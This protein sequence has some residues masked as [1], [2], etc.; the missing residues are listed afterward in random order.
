MRAADAIKPCCPA[1]LPA[2]VS[3][4]TALPGRDK[5][6]AFFPPRTP[7]FFGARGEQTFM[8]VSPLNYSACVQAVAQ[9]SL[10]AYCSALLPPAQNFFCAS[11]SRCL[12]VRSAT[13]ARSRATRSRPWGADF[14][15]S[16][17]AQQPSL[18]AQQLS[19]D[20]ARIKVAFCD[21]YGAGV[22]HST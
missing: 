7:P 22:Y 9:P 1:V 13:P 19:V 11:G 15:G 4:L 8:V 10:A 14:Y 21:E 18:A 20:A 5:R 12:P 16:F 17:P 3:N 2:A 6:F